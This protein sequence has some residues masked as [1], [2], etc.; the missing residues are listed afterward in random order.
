MKRLRY[1]VVCAIIARWK[2]AGSSADKPVSCFTKI[3]VVGP[4]QNALSVVSAIPVEE[5]IA[6][7]CRIFFM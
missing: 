5:E 6:G 4:T 1:R 3:M 2:T 7:G